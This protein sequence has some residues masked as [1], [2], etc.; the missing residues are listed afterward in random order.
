MRVVRGCFQRFLQLTL[1]V[2]LVAACVTPSPDGD[3]ARYAFP[4][5][6]F[7]EQLVEIEPA[8]PAPQIS[9]IAQISRRDEHLTAV[10]LD[11]FLFSPILRLDD[12]T[13]GLAVRW[14]I[15]PVADLPVT[16][17]WQ[18]VRNLYEGGHWK[19]IQGDGPDELNLTVD[20]AL[21]SLSAFKGNAECRF[22]SKIK[23]QHR[24]LSVIVTTRSFSCIP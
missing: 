11:P 16:R 10:F 22:P 12:E 21:Y 7:A 2:L 8:P 13:G 3:A 18:S 5:H 1:P 24:G 4:A 23:L 14:F 9:L 19:S 6:F 20:G 17:L 15:A